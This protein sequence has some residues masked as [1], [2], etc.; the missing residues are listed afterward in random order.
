[1][2]SW[3]TDLRTKDTREDTNLSLVIRQARDV[4]NVSR[5]KSEERIYTEIIITHRISDSVCFK[6]GWNTMT[7]RWL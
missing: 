7:V 2:R 4:K 5:W 6:K 3:D 1:M